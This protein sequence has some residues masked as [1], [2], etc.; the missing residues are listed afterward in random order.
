ML[1]LLSLPAAAHHSFAASFDS[2]R[3]IT[4][5]GTV[6]RVEW[7]NPHM[8]FLL[9]VRGTDGRAVSWICEAAGLNTLSRHGW[10]RD[11][12]KTGDKVQVIGYPARGGTPVASAREVILGDGRKMPGGSPYDGGPQP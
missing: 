6:T 12:I 2:G 11:L 9:S 1:L 5:A 4:L 10:S 3:K 8:Y 7:A